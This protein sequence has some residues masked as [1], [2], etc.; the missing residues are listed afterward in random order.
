MECNQYVLTMHINFLHKTRVHCR[1]PR[2]FGTPFL[3]NTI[4]NTRFTVVAFLSVTLITSGQSQYEL[5][6][7]RNGPIP[8][9]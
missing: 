9:M 2:F 6:N 8:L 1:K 5:T 3:E 7:M 4:L